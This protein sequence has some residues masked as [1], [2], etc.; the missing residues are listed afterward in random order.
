MIN[1]QVHAELNP[2]PLES[3]IFCRG[4][5]K[6]VPQRETTYLW[7]RNARKPKNYCKDCYEKH[8]NNLRNKKGDN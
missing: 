4:C 6:P 7:L 3:L 5:G 8:K 1:L 2:S